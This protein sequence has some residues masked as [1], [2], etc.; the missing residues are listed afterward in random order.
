MM[1]TW[2]HPTKPYV[3]A[4]RGA[5][6][7]APECSVQ[8]YEKADILGADFWGVDIHLSRDQELVV[9]HNAACADNV[10]V[11]DLTLDEIIGKA[12]QDGVSAEPLQHII[13]L[14][15]EKNAGIYADI[16]DAAAAVPAARLLEL[17]GIER[18]IIGGFDA[19]TVTALRDTGC[20]YPISMRVPADCDPFDTEADLI[21]LCRSFRDRAQELL[22]TA[23]FE[24]AHRRGKLVMSWHEEDSER[25][26]VLR[27]LPLFGICSERPEL[28]HPFTQPGDWPLKIVVHRGACEVTSENSL[29]AA[30]A[31]FA[32]GFD[33]M[34][35][36]VQQ[37]RDGVLFLQHD[38]E[39]S[40]LTTGFGGVQ[41]R[42]W[43]YLQTLNLKRRGMVQ[44]TVPQQGL[45]SLAEGLDVA[46]F[47]NKGFYLELKQSDPV[48]VLRLVE[49]KAML[50][51]CLFWSYQRSYL[52]QIHK[53]QP[54]AKLIVRRQ[55]YDTLSACLSELRPSVIEFAL[56]DDWA[57]FAACRAAKVDTMIAYMG[58][59][60]QVF[61]KIADARPDLVNLH[62]PFEF[63][64]YLCDM[65]AVKEIA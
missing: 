52:E 2:C 42:S 64:H 53:M 63:T 6:A 44:A 31:T 51:A 38:S 7:Y 37:S 21:H 9:F 62:Y 18:A 46:R 1:A 55:D 23:F 29:Q 16:K 24:E 28:V 61:A 40:D 56:H 17:M 34:E 60:H 41:W 19:A 15:R 65:S 14:A 33:Y 43:P 39:L 26:A 22:D 47:Y 13:A 32:G 3:I 10:L 54:N 48:D 5:S 49:D 58:R 12:V 30:H 45:P 4:H 35:T 11:C 59:D 57:E 36:D 27:D 25:M 20:R 8:A 50:P